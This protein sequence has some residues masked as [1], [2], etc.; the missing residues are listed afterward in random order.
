M[1]RPSVDRLK[2]YMKGM[3]TEQKQEFAKSCSTSLGN[4]NQIIYV[5]GKCSASL[6]IRIDKASAGAIPC[7]DLCPDAD[8]EYIRQK[9]LSGNGGCYV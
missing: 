9:A 7:D 8:F 4:L 2:N 1:K 3:T 6:A 5:N